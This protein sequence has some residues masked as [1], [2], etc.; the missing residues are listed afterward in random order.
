[1]EVKKSPKANLENKRILFTEIGVAV[2]LLL[3]LIA[4]EWN[5]HYPT[6]TVADYREQAAPEEEMTPV[7][8]PEIPPPPP[9]ITVIKPVVVVTDVIKIVNDDVEINEPPIEEINVPEEDTAEAEVNDMPQEEEISFAMVDEKPKF[10]NRDE[11]EFAR[12]VFKNFTYPLDTKEK[13]IQGRIIMSFTVSATGLVTKVQIIQGI[14]PLV[15]AEMVRIVSSSPA[16]TPGKQHH[17]TVAVQY[18][19][20]IVFKL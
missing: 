18:N 10:M 2:A 9:K 4:F 3:L 19:F 17:K 12:W 15:D 11:N 6:A 5:T 8:L 20:P 7:I 14:H 1:M 16:W 13:L